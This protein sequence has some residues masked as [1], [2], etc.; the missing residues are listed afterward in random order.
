MDL[1]MT[2]FAATFSALCLVL[3]PVV[4]A[5]VPPGTGTETPAESAETDPSLAAQTRAEHMDA[6]FA[7]LA[8]PETENWEQVQNQIFQNWRRS[9]SDSMDLLLARALE[10]VDQRDYETALIHLDDL[11]RLDPGF[12]E[13]WNQRATVYFLMED[14]GRS[15]SD[16]AHVLALEPRHFGALAGLGIILDRTGDAK[17]AVRAYRRALEINPHL[18]GAREGIKTLSPE[19]DGQEL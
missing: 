6:L 13:G 17:G 18:P 10:A 2:M 19:V 4:L 3:G 9:G 11:V 12:A 5:E 15:V 1:Q 14:Y 16:I 8:D 7:R